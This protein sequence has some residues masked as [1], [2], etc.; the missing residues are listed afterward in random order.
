MSLQI[1]PESSSQSF[2]SSTKTVTKQLCL[3][4]SVGSLYTQIIDN[5]QNKVKPPTPLLLK[6]HSHRH[7][8]TPKKKKKRNVPSI[9]QRNDLKEDHVQLRA[10]RMHMKLAPVFIVFCTTLTILLLLAAIL[11]NSYNIC[12]CRTTE[13]IQRINNK[14]MA[15]FHSATRLSAQCNSLLSLSKHSSRTE[16]SSYKSHS[17]ASYSMYVWV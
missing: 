6:S 10:I 5:A 16:W 4:W 17:W 2:C 11:W 14:T 13:F 1:S 3:N 7:Y 15:T 9:H 8:S 12:L